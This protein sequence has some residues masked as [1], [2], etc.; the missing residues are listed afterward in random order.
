MVRKRT[1]TFRDWHSDE[2]YAL[3][4]SPNGRQLASASLDGTVRVW[5]ALTGEQRQVYRKHEAAT[6]A[7]A[8]SAD[9]QRVISAGWDRTLR[10]WLASSGRTIKCV[11][12]DHV[13]YHVAFSPDGT[14]IAAED[15]TRTYIHDGRSLESR[16]YVDGRGDAACLLRLGQGY[17]HAVLLRGIE[18]IVRSGTSYSNYTFLPMLSAANIRMRP[19]RRE[20]A[21]L[22]SGRIELYRLEG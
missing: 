18:V 2:V 13:Y 16:G 5:D 14:R 8:F 4:F 21:V 20:F 11:P 15:R 9:G 3:A 22:S 12:T 17:E 7:V 6:F 19:H 10:M 1:L